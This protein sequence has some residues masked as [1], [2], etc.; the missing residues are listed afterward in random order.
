MCAHI[1][2]GPVPNVPIWDARD[3]PLP[4]I[5][6]PISDPPNELSHLLQVEWVR[7]LSSRPGNT[8]YFSLRVRPSFKSRRRL[9]SG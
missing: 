7:I 4:P 8:A 5:D 3:L 2:V 9:G 1:D 6:A